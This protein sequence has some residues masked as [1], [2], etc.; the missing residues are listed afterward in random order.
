MNER[1]NSVSVGMFVGE[2]EEINTKLLNVQKELAELDVEKNFMSQVLSS[3]PKAMSTSEQDGSSAVGN[4][5]A[6]VP[7]RNPSTS[8][9]VENGDIDLADS[10]S[11][12]SSMDSF[13]GFLRKES[14][15]PL[16]E[17]G[18]K[19]NGILQRLENDACEEPSSLAISL[20]PEKYQRAG[21]NS[22]VVEVHAGVSPSLNHAC[23]ENGDFS[24][25]FGES[26]INNVS[27]N[28][29]VPL[30]T[31]TDEN[32][33]PTKVEFA[34]TTAMN[35]HEAVSD[36]G[37]FSQYEEDSNQGGE[38]F[39]DD[40]DVYYGERDSKTSVASAIKHTSK[41]LTN[42]QSGAQSSD[43]SD[44]GGTVS[45]AVKR[46]K[47]PSD[48]SSID[49]SISQFQDHESITYES[50][51]NGAAGPKDVV[52]KGAELKDEG[53]SSDTE[54]PLK[55][56]GNFSEGEAKKVKEPET[57]NE[58]TTGLENAD[59]FPRQST[60][61][62]FVGLSYLNDSAHRIEETRNTSSVPDDLDNH[63]DFTEVMCNPTI[64]ADSVSTTKLGGNEPETSSVQQ[65]KW[66]VW[67]KEL[68]DSQTVPD[69]E[70]RIAVELHDFKTSP[71]YLHFSSETGSTDLRDIFGKT[72]LRREQ[73]NVEI[74]RINEQLTERSGTQFEA[75][76]PHDRIA[77]ILSERRKADEAERSR[78]V[79]TS[80]R[81]TD[82]ELYT[83][84]PLDL[85][86]R[87]SA[88][89]EFIEA[90]TALH[91][92]MT[93]NEYLA[94]IDKLFEKLRAIEELVRGDIETEENVK[95][96]LAKHVVSDIII[97][98][99]GQAC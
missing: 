25:D 1:G 55:L 28:I 76:R 45:A 57:E 11:G 42:S 22:G 48:D 18:M 16:D 37:S 87:S 23:F 39:L 78:F 92:D 89:R 53:L 3:P 44:Q 30:V 6:E 59:N 95:D 17:N 80:Q 69:N 36:A 46:C 84:R 65:P 96:K 75:A 64:V 21:R 9:I 70:R 54:T 35:G 27:H 68:E 74:G 7:Q 10:E 19:Q 94:E 34:E 41:T 62:E 13:E 97:P 71:P 49:E 56:N 51:E 38:F 81:D 20:S 32:G 86:E 29:N 47:R 8:E 91:E 15:H 90:E 83:S 85:A 73:P 2:R 4:Y 58:F 99:T 63:S 61:S 60:P 77:A 43:M 79:A 66:F 82:S 93:L 12:V 52:T 14:G 72:C 50:F 40:F 98:F 24:R 31:V 67:S 26:L 5:A 88:P 33:T